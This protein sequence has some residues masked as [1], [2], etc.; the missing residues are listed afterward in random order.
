MTLQELIR[1]FRA[2]SH[3]RRASPFWADEDLMDWLNDAQAQACVRARLIREDARREVCRIGLSPARHTYALHPSVFEIIHL[4]LVPLVPEGRTRH[5]RLVSRE[6]LDAEQPDWRDD[7]RPASRA[8]QDDT[9]LRVVG[10]IQEGDALMLE[11]YRL[12]LEPMQSMSDEPEI[13]PAHH[14]H[15]IQWALHKAFSVPDAEGFDPARSALAE[16]AFTAYF[17]PLPGS[18]MRRI[19]REDVG[20]YTRAILQ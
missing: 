7:E 4:R 9:S 10:A 17:G 2:L 14:E 19:T 13:H 6:L 12:P 8:I 5:V 20:H 3:D 15:L 18:D 16:Q 1:R 11:C